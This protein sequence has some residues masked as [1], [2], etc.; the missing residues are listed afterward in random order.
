M[1]E[2]ITLHHRS[3]YS[4]KTTSTSQCH[5][6]QLQGPQER[7]RYFHLFWFG[8]FHI[9]LRNDINLLFGNVVALLSDQYLFHYEN[10]IWN[11]RRCR[12][13][14][15]WGCIDEVTKTL[16]AR[17]IMCGVWLNYFDVALKAF[18]TVI[19]YLCSKK[20]GAGRAINSYSFTIYLYKS[21][22]SF[23]LQNTVE[24]YA[25]SL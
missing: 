10:N 18:P 12:G 6:K 8:C 19:A 23:L 24:I 22:G 13:R 16:V 20:V 21:W 1:I 7:V 3:N 5:N 25:S 14:R 17:C 11:G 9:P 4:S 15:R 2:T